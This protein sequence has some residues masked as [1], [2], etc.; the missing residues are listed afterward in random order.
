M[1]RKQKL[2]Q[3]DDLIHELQNSDEQPSTPRAFKQELRGQ[4]LN[5][6]DKSGFSLATLGRWAGTA[7]AL[8]VLALIVVF[9]WNSIGRQS[10]AASAY[11]GTVDVPGRDEFIV[12]DQLRLE[13]PMWVELDAGWAEMTAESW[14]SLDGT[15]FRG[16]VVDAAG[17]QR[18]FAQGDGQ[19]LW[20]G[21][22]DTSVER[23]ETVSL[24]YFDVY[25]ALAQAEGWAG[26]RTMPPFY[27]DLGWGGLVQSVLRLDWN[28]E[29]AQC[30]NDFLVEPPLGVSSQGGE[31]EPYGWGVSLI[32]T[33]TT[34]NGRSLTTY[35]IEYSPNQ[36]GIAGSQYRVV[37]LNS[38]NDTV[39]EVAD[40]DGDTLLRRLERVS[41]Q[42]MTSADLPED[43]FTQ[44]PAEMGVSF[45]L[46][47]GRVTTETPLLAEPNGA[48][49]ATLAADTPVTLSGLMNNQLSVVQNGITWQFVTVPNVGQGW[50]DEA[51][52]QWPLTS[53]GQLVDLDTS[54]LP[55]AVPVQTQLTIL[56]T[57]QTELQAI[58]PQAAGDELTRLQE[59]LEAIEAE[60]ERLEYLASFDSL[61]QDGIDVVSW[62]LDQ[63]EI[64]L[65]SELT[66]TAFAIEEGNDD[67][68]LTLDWLVLER[69]SA[70]YQLFFH[71]RDGQGNV[72]AQADQP[73][74]DAD[75][76]ST[77]WNAGERV[78]TTLALALPDGLAANRYDLLI[79]LHDPA[80]GARL[81]VTVANPRQS[82]DGGTAV[83]LTDWFVERKADLDNSETI[84]PPVVHDANDVW[85]ISATQHAR[86]SVDAAVTLEIT[87]GYQFESD[88]EVMLKPLYANPNW[89]SASGERS[90]ID[91]LSEA[92]TLTEKSGIQTIIFS[93][94]PAEMRQIVGTDQPVLVMQLGYL[95]DDGNGR[96]ELN[97]LAMPTLTEFEIDLTRTEKMVVTG[98]RLWIVNA[99]QLPRSNPSEAII[100]EVTVGYE[101]VSAEEAI[102]SLS[103]IHPEWETHTSLDE[104]RYPN[105]NALGDS[106]PVQAGTGSVTITATVEPET[107]TS[108]I[109][110][111]EF[112]LMPRLW[113]VDEDGR[114]VFSPILMGFNKAMS[115]N[116]QSVEE[117]SYP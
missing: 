34:A 94:S 3:F 19:F 31:Y 100:L 9:S 60:I 20:R 79:G 68:H 43:Q 33:E 81:P 29:G 110:S 61:G 78:R 98:N 102:L 107:I 50:V 14:Q 10:G 47:E 114:I 66:L 101:L 63:L 59:A 116:V 57:Y 30:I 84:D 108:A 21:T 24:Q 88:E 38:D 11:M 36:D 70:D 41:H 75:R 7:V 73:L 97:I 55:T 111:D 39:V 115:F 17:R 52:L 117:I 1:S 27:D 74:Q 83:W 105:Y 95:S 4:L 58:L 106:F 53:D 2:D 45:V 25:H 40:Y 13:F 96:R 89:E 15:F 71:L 42:L 87:V 80:S 104:I 18:V 54:G 35:R 12:H 28:C 90:P 22:Y 113:A 76:L 64:G 92:I 69:P 8:G 99:T 49:E 56:R 62:G 48:A 32:E 109:G 72:A 6:Y 93:A 112:G 37:K 77:N 86:S 44:L 51:Y 67:L 46:P 26:T 82:A 85:L 5:Q 65:G 91:G 16:E 23:M 103:F